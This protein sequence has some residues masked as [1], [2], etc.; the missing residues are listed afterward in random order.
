MV[1]RALELVV[2]AS[3]SSPSI[4]TASTSAT[5][6]VFTPPVGISVGKP[7]PSTTV[8]GLVTLSVWLML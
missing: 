8:L 4:R 5:C 7:M 6:M 1:S 3:K 2:P